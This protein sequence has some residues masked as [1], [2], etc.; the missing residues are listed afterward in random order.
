[1]SRVMEMAH[2]VALFATGTMLGRH[3]PV[4]ACRFA[5]VGIMSDVGP[6]VWPVMATG[7][8]EAC[9]LP[10]SVGGLTPVSSFYV[11]GSK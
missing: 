11:C 7:R 8:V 10:S 2:V 3:W 1:M 9:P 5:V 4:V 6:Q